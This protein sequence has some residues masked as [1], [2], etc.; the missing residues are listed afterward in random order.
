M[1]KPFRFIVRRPPGAC[2]RTSLTGLTRSHPHSRRATE[3]ACERIVISR[4]TVEPETC[5]KRR[6]RQAAIS[7]GASMRSDTSATGSRRMT[8]I[9]FCS[10]AA[11]RFWE[12]TSRL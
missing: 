2:R 5:F 10:R 8:S 12:L 7:I 1:Q 4:S 11:P 6:S 9:I 3:Q